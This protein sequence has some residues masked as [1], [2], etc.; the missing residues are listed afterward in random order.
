MA[1]EAEQELPATVPMRENC[2]DTVRLTIKS[3]HGAGHC[4][5]FLRPDADR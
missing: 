5:F 1:Y 3:K 2:R 4:Y